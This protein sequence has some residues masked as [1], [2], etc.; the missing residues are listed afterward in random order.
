MKSYHDNIGLEAG[1]CT[2]RFWQ[3]ATV[4]FSDDVTNNAELAFSQVRRICTDLRIAHWV[5]VLF[6]L[7][8]ERP[9]AD[10]A[11]EWLHLAPPKDVT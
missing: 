8:C 1:I 9:A 2:T 3:A 6:V 11:K 5:Q 7:M 4:L 10:Y